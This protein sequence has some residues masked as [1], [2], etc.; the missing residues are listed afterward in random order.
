[1]KT[2]EELKEL[3]QEVETLNKKLSELAPEE[4]E[5]VNVRTYRPQF[6]FCTTDVKGDTMQGLGSIRQNDIESIQ[7]LKDASLTAVYGVRG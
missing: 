4:L 5:Q 6:Y 3:K 7:L 1:M 2:P